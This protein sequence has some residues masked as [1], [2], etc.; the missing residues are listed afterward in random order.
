MMG[1]YGQRIVFDGHKYNIGWAGWSLVGWVINCWPDARNCYELF[2][3][4]WAAEGKRNARQLIEGGKPGCVQL[5]H[6]YLSEFNQS[7]F[8]PSG[9]LSHVSINRSLD[10]AKSDVSRPES[11][12]AAELE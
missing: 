12:I 9:D 8:T 7:L 6:L 10:R 2:M 3:P 5:L 1:P 4:S 11:R